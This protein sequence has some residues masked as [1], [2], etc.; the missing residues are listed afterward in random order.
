MLRLVVYALY[1]PCNP[2]WKQVG[3]DHDWSGK[4]LSSPN[5]H[6]LSNHPSSVPLLPY[7]SK[8]PCN[9]PSQSSMP[10][11]RPLPNQRHLHLCTY[12][13]GKSGFPFLEWNFEGRTL[14]EIFVLYRRLAEVHGGDEDRKGV[15]KEFINRCEC[16]CEGYEVNGNWA[17]KRTHQAWLQISRYQ[18]RKLRAVS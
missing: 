9:T 16:P 6:L 18:S 3:D 10:P 11:P 1:D 12:A 7:N 14:F 17:S 15:Q 13:Q 8:T 4:F 2:L 5:K